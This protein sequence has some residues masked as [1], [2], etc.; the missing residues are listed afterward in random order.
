MPPS[1]APPLVRL[2][3]ILRRS[4]P[5]SGIAGTLQRVA[6]AVLPE[7]PPA[8]PARALPALPSPDLDVARDR[9]R[10]ALMEARQAMGGMIPN[11]PPPAESNAESANHTVSPDLDRLRAYLEEA[12]QERAALREEVAALR[13]ALAALRVRL[14][15]L[16]RLLPAGRPP[17]PAGRTEAEEP[18]AAPPISPSE[19]PVQPESVAADHPAPRPLLAASADD[20]EAEAPAVDALQP[21]E[22]AAPAPAADATALAAA[23]GA[24]PPSPANETPPD[25]ADAVRELRERVLRA[26]RD[27]V[28]AA[29]TVGTRIQLTPAPEQPELAG[30][31]ARLSAEPF[32]EH[33]EPLPDHPG[34]LRV[35]LRTPLRWEQFGGLIERALDR[36]L[37][38]GGVSWSHGAVRVRLNGGPPWSGGDAADSPPADQG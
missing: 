26:L 6:I 24:T 29:G 22:T 31:A 16:E 14:D 21:P 38:Q 37:A 25:D 36:P 12:E 32:V 10:R 33:A 5:R 11:D 15:G 23:P 4:P 19:A 28:F 35:T 27:R 20:T 8:P 17:E 30:I 34:G 3:R 2:S 7:Q 9:A 1:N 13:G 18:P